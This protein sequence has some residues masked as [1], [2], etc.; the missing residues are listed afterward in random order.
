MSGTAGDLDAILHTLREVEASLDRRV[1]RAE[2]ANL[3]VWG[4]VGASI[5]AFYQVV[6]WNH[7]PW[8]AALG[9][10]LA[11]VW[12]GPILAGYVLTAIVGARL[13]RVTRDPAVRRDLR[14]GLV[15]GALATLLAA[16]LVLTERYEYVYGGVTAVV[17]AATL[18]FSVP[19]P[20]TPFRRWALASGAGMLLVGLTLAARPIELAGLVAA[21]AFLVGLVGLGTVRYRLAE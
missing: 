20:R 4:L 2:G 14:M 16:A 21:L 3:M 5:F 17:G 19:A 10:L 12:L 15:P 1:A 11:W 7:A 18:A 13:G 8:S 9:P 6:E